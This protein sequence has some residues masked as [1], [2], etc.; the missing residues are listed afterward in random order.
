MT[1]ARRAAALSACGVAAVLIQARYVQLGGAPG[2]KPLNTTIGIG[3][4]GR[5]ASSFYPAVGVLSSV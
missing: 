5:Y 4:D 2:E 1:V 3:V